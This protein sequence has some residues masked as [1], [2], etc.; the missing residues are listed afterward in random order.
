MRIQ[1]IAWP[2]GIREKV[3]TKHGLSPDEVEEAIMDRHAYLRIARRGRYFVFGRS[4]SGAYIIS[5]VAVE[6]GTARVIS[7]R[8]M[9]AQEQR[10]YQRKGK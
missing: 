6:R 4:N 9:T 1:D 3:E 7:A 2:A 10:T 5:V 8:S